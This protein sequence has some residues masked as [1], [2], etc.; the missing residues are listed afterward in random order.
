[1]EL[2]IPESLEN[3]KWY[4]KRDK[5]AVNGQGPF[6]TQELTYYIQRGRLKAHNCISFDLESW[7][8]VATVFPNILSSTQVLQTLQQNFAC[9]DVKNASWYVKTP[10]KPA[11]VQ[12]PLNTSLIVKYIQNGRLKDHHFLSYN[13]EKWFDT[14]ALFPHRLS[15]AQIEETLAEHFDNRDMLELAK[16][17]IQTRNSSYS[18]RQVKYAALRF[19]DVLDKIPGKMFLLT[20]VIILASSN[21]IVKKLI[22]IGEQ[23]LIAGHNPITFCNVLFA[24]NFCALIALMCVYRREMKWSSFRSLT[25]KDWV[26]IGVVSTL[27]VAIAPT[28]I[29]IALGQTTVTNVVLIGRIE[30]PLLLILSILFLKEK[31]NFWQITGSFIAFGGVIITVVIQQNTDVSLG[32]GEILAA[33]GAVSFTLSTIVT[34]RYLMEIPLGVLTV[35]RLFIGTLLFFAIAMYMLGPSHFSDLVSPFL[36]KWMLFYGSIIIVFGQLCW[37]HGLRKTTASDAS[38]MTS[39]TPIAGVLAALIIL[40]EIPTAAQLIGG[41]AILGGIFFAQYGA[42]LQ[43]RKTSPSEMHPQELMDSGIGFKGL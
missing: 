32:K 15:I 2:S 20:A 3:H 40:T 36:W 33:I 17:Q 13:K 1:M 14:A 11:R 43:P 23:N 30:P 7:Q 41:V 27:S 9:T 18:I 25:R 19:Q 6:T 34:K 38:L 5:K 8:E 4:I 12:G 10:K 28:V 24:G 37:F 31:S 16:S 42:A 22:E 21:A 26:S 35:L 29:V 39:F